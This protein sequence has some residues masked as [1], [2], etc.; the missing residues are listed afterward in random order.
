MRR[1][2]ILL[3]L[4]FV[5]NLLGSSAEAAATPVAAL[6][7][8]TAI[9]AGGCFWCMQPPYDALKNEGVLSTRVGYTGGTTE[10]PT[11]EQTSSGNTGHREA[12]EVVFDPKKITYKKLLEVFWKNVDP[13]DSKGQFCDK[14]EQYSSAVYYMTD[15]Q[16]Q[17]FQESLPI[18]KQQ[19]KLK[20]EIAT[21]LLPAKKFY[22]AEDSHQN[23]YL[24]NPLRYKF[25][26]AGCGRDARLKDVWGSP[27]Y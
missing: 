17:A 6:K 18:V 20:G 24:K 13:L 2:S 23:Y 14:G 26:R 22:A 8:E 3:A 19:L 15:A 12:I 4:F 21:L 7:T 16:K 11:Y 25:Y 10:N 1:F 5:G 27:D 9:F